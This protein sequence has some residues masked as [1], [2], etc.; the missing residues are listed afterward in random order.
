MAEIIIP[1]N[2]GMFDSTRIIETVEGFPRG[3]KA[4]NAEFFAKMISCF[5]KDGMA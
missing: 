1:V 5:Y 4:V 2:G 3:D